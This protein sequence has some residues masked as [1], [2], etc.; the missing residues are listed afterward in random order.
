MSLHWHQLLGTFDCY[1]VHMQMSLIAC[2]SNSSSQTTGTIL[3]VGGIP[4]W[5]FLRY[6]CFKCKSHHNSRSTVFTSVTQYN[7][8]VTLNATVNLTTFRL[9]LNL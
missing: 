1:F 3:D 6:S 4:T 5:A 2:G 9:L 7:V 8:S